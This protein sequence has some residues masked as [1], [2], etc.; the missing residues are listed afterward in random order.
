MNETPH[1]LP[2][3]TDNQPHMIVSALEAGTL[4]TRKLRAIPSLA[5]YFKHSASNWHFLLDLGLRKDFESYPPAVKGVYE[6]RGK[7]L[8]VPQDVAESCRKGG[9]D[10]A[11]V[12][13]VILTHVHWD[14]IGDHTPF[15]KATFTLGEGG[16]AL[17]DDGY[18]GSPTSATLS[19][20]APSA[21]TVF[22]AQED[23]T[24]SIGPFPHALDYF[25]DGGVYIIHTPDHV[26]GHITVLAR[27]S[28]DGAWMYFGGDVADDPR[29]VTDPSTTDIAG[30]LDPSDIARV[31]E[32]VKMPRV[33]F[34]LSH[35]CEWA[36]E[37]SDAFL[38]GRIVPKV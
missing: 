27:T 35:D 12:E 13:N 29:L 31:R 18:P 8:E 26:A 25:G 32:L 23:F 16:K 11:V 21:R 33:E 38:P 36:R 1:P 9:V 34:V 10:P 15:T 30:C 20:S 17:L 24:T 4:Y 6:Q 3:P 37:N 28:S 19:D 5:F 7:P 2:T 22:L 14:H